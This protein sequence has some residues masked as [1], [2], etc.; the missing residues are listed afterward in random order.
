VKETNKFNKLEDCPSPEDNF[1][2]WLGY[3]KANWR[4]I[5]KMM[6]ND[7]KVIKTGDKVLANKH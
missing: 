7:K 2:D 6:K 4:K 3:Q 5:R 1:K